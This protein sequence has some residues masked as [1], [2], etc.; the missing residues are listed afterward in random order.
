M[1]IPRW[2]D[3]AMELGCSFSQSKSGLG[4]LVTV[5]KHDAAA[6]FG[7]GSY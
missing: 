2:S 6:G 1:D 4:E 3:A 5:C 7:L